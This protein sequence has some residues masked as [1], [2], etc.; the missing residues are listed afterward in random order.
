MTTPSPFSSLPD[1]FHETW[2]KIAL[3]EAEIA[4]ENGETPMGCVIVQMLPDGSAKIV[5]KARNQT[6]TLKDPTAHAEMIAITQATAATGDWRLNDCAL[7]V[8]KE[9]CPMCGGA[10]VL[11]RPSF[12]CWAVSDPKRGAQ[13]VFRIFSHPGVNHHPNLRSG[14]CEA[15]A[16]SVLQSF[17]RQRRKE[18][19]QKSSDSPVATAPE[20]A[21]KES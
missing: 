6:E 9:P 1:S 5:G 19:A 17:F 10:I 18:N 11:A 3:K 7:Y 2:M 8:T 13:T 12:V 4:A 14:I 21:S 15:E 16:L 20:Q